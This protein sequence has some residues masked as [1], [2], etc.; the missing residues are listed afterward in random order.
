M[1]ST[2]RGH[3]G[4][5]VMLHLGAERNRL[6]PLA[7][8]GS[9]HG[10]PAAV[11]GQVFHD[12]GRAGLIVSR[13]GPKG[14]VRLTHP[15]EETTVAMVLQA[16]EGQRALSF[17]RRETK[18][19]ACNVEQACQIGKFLA[20]LDRSVWRVMENTTLAELFA[21]SSADT[22]QANPSLDHISRFEAP[23]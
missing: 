1:I 9:A 20:R 7:E 22:S 18:G 5:Q 11:L 3:Y 16:V 23:L 17:C 10:I 6:V 15:L 19:H 14:G 4:L 12:L 21:D 8:I 13:R 2:S